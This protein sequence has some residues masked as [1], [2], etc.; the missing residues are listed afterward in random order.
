MIHYLE[1]SA[2][3]KLLTLEAESVALEG[4]LDGLNDDDVVACL[5]METELRRMAL[6]EDIPQEGVTGVLRGIRML[7]VPR[8][9]FHSAGLLP[10]KDLRSLDAIHLA[11]ALSV[12]AD[13]VISYDHRLLTAASAVGLHTVTPA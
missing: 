3:A 12:A 5:L 2:A 11:S 6:R 4:F 8:D 13:S 1:T 7:G 10:M 9:V